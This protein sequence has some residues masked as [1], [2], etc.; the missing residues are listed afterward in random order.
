MMTPFSKAVIAVVN[1]S[2][3]PALFTVPPPPLPFVSP[4]LT[5]L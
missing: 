1:F 4:C 2:F 3:Y 5:F